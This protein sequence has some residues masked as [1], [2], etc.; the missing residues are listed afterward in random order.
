[1]SGRKCVSNLLTNTGRHTRKAIATY[2]KQRGTQSPRHGLKHLEG[3]RELVATLLEAAGLQ[4]ASIS[5]RPNT[6]L[7]GRYRAEKTWDLIVLADGRLVAVIEFM[8][9]GSSFN[10]R[11]N[12]RAEESLT[13]A[14]DLWAAYEHGA[15]RLSDRPWL[16]CFMILENVPELRRKVRVRETHVEVFPE[17]KEASYADRYDQLLT[18][19]VRARLYDAGCFL[20][21]SR[22]GGLKGAYREPNPELSFHNFATSLLA[23]AFAVAQTQPPGPPE[24][25]KVEAGPASPNDE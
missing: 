22:E 19:L 24:P 6:V 25:P 14:S 3:F 13:G 23:R 11:L 8:A 21:S 17:F 5:S 4:S 20:M 16:G 2:W 10:K 15:F 18:R 1:M 12:C 9:P 7:P